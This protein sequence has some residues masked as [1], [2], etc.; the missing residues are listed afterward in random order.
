MLLAQR[1]LVSLAAMKEQDQ[2]KGETIRLTVSHA[3]HPGDLPFNPGAIV[4]PPGEPIEVELK[5]EIGFRT[6][7]V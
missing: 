4:G 6:H 3:S 2:S 1:C 7:R 5:R